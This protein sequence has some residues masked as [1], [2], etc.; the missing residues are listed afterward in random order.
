LLLSYIVLSAAVAAAL[1]AVE[2]KD[3]NR[4]VLALAA[5]SVLV[6]LAHYLAGAWLLAV[7]RL[8][9]YGGAVT[10]LMLAAVHSGGERGE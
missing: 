8:S 2:L 9:V 1:A 5:M 10:M 7:F 4:A 6:A 3:L